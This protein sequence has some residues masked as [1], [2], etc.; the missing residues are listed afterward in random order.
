MIWLQHRQHK[1]VLTWR[2]VVLLL[3]PLV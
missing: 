1:N 2:E 3:F